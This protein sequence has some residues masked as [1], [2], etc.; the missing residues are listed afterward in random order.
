MNLLDAYDESEEIVK[1]E[2]FTRGQKKLP[3]TAIVCFNA[4]LIE[5]IKKREDFEEYSDT[6]VCGESI[7]IYKTKVNDKDVILY[8]T[9]IG[10]PATASIMEEIHSRGVKNFIFFG[11]CGELTSDLKKGAFIIPT[12]AF[13]D[14]G[15]SYHYIPASDF[16]E[17][18]T[19]TKLAEIFDKYHIKYELTKVWTTD[20]LYKETIKK[21]KSRIEQG[22]KV[23]EMEC[24]SIMAVSISRDINCYQ[25]LYTDD[26]LDGDSWDLRTLKSDRTFILK[27]CLEIAFKIIQEI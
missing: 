25:F 17:V 21:T 6:T 18:K 8:K 14:E 12:Q 15:T 4:D 22:C 16:V 20:A 5:E 13:R 3:E 27:E 24:A 19:A 26:T 1:A 9:L 2:I 11:S 10:G 23:V 7:K